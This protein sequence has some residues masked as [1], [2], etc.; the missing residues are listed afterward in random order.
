[1]SAEILVLPPLQSFFQ[2][3]GEVASRKALTRAMSRCSAG[4]AWR[5]AA[6]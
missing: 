1:M 5:S 6:I 4:G 3:S 2:D